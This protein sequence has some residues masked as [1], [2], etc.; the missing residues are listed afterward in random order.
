MLLNVPCIEINSK[1][2][3]G[4]TPLNA[5]SWYGY[6]P[7]VKNLVAQGADL[8]IKNDNSQTA[9]DIARE[10]GHH[11]IAQYLKEARE[12]RSQEKTVAPGGN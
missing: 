1:T 7:I 4:T 12:A 8:L 6:L 3:N 5:A 9:E 2:K 11:E 10:K